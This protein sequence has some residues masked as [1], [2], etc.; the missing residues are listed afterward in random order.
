VEIAVADGRDLTIDIQVELLDANGAMLATLTGQGEIEENETGTIRARQRLPRE[1]S[2]AIA[3]F[4][5]AAS[6]RK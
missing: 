2:A 3:S 1:V 4:R 5:V 6:P